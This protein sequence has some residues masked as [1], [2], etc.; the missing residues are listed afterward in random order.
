[1]PPEPAR[2]GASGDRGRSLTSEFDALIGRASP[3]SPCWSSS[4]PTWIALRLLRRRGLTPSLRLLLA[5]ILLLS[6][7]CTLPL[8][9]P[10]PLLPL[11][12]PLPRAHVIRHTRGAASATRARWRPALLSLP[13]FFLPTSLRPTPTTPAMTSRCTFIDVCVFCEP[14]A[15]YLLTVSCRRRYL[16]LALCQVASIVGEGSSWATSPLRRGTPKL[17]LRL[18]STAPLRSSRTSRK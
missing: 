3:A 1:M 8:C 4:A 13:S 6:I 15:L 17:S 11:A 16:V 12:P 10:P 5:Q 2:P 7:R 9:P 18:T 14:W